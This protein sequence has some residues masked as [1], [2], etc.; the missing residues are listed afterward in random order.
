MRQ[1]FHQLV[2]IGLSAAV[3][4][5][6]VVNLVESGEGSGGNGATGGGGAGAQGGGGGMGTG[7][8]M[9]SGGATT[10]GTGTGGMGGGA[11]CGG[12]SGVLC[13]PNEYCD[14]PDDRCGDSDSMGVCLPMPQACPGVYLPTCACDGKV[15]GNPCDAASAGQDVSN[16]AQ[17]MAPTPDMFGCGHGFCTAAKEYCS[18]TLSDVPGVPDF[19]SCVPLP[20]DCG[21]SPSCACLPDPCGA[22]IAGTCAQDPNGGGIRVTCPG[23]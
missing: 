17:C 21:A 5:G 1:A 9:G 8:I 16:L 14:Y 10:G 13:G 22:P 12:L 2:F 23:G 19:F 6:C 20:A 15:Y 7:G 4:G 3:M 18:T 11:P